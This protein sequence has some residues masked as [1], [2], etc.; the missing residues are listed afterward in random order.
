[1]GAAEAVEDVIGEDVG[2]GLGVE[3]CEERRAGDDAHAGV[4]EAF[5]GAEGVKASDGGAVDEAGGD[6]VELGWGVSW[7]EA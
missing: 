1:M 4:E 3:A 6:V 5:V 7:G 2:A